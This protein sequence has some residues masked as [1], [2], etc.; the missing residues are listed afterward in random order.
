MRNV[1]RIARF[2]AAGALGC[3]LLMPAAAQDAARQA[4]RKAA[5][6]SVRG[7]FQA[8]GLVVPSV[9]G[10][11]G[12]PLLAAGG[13]SLG[14]GLELRAGQWIPIRSQTTY[15]S[16]GHSAVDE[17]LFLYR[18]FLGWREALETG[19]SVD[20]G[21]LKLDLLAGGAVSLS[22]YSGTALVSAYYSLVAAPRLL[23]PVKAKTIPGFA[24][25][26]SLP[27]EYM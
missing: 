11:D 13:F 25:T 17:S 20:L 1:C 14:L 9:N 18:G 23:I 3:A 21:E 4:A 15:Y 7:D 27:L 26:A 16:T 8:S 22:Q 19:Y 24:I 5:P 10:A 12:R 2:L 6:L